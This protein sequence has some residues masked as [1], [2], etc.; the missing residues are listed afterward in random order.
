[1]KGLAMYHL[2][3]YQFSFDR[4]G[5]FLLEQDFK[6][7]AAPL[8]DQHANHIHARIAELYNGGTV[9]LWNVSL[10]ALYESELTE[11]FYQLLHVMFVDTKL[12]KTWWTDLPRSGAERRWFD[13]AVNYACRKKHRENSHPVNSVIVRTRKIMAEARKRKKALDMSKSNRRESD[14]TLWD[15]CAESPC[16]NLI[17]VVI[18]MAHMYNTM[19]AV[20]GSEPRPK[21]F[22]AQLAKAVE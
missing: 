6:A 20:F 9:G 22:A 19:A 7:L 18:N 5:H 12:R 13:Q 17:Y 21:S 16:Q 4:H 11:L 15:L 3:L 8:V 2:G 1:M 10:E 14:T